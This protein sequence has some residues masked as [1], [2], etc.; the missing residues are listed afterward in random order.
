MQ[1][2]TPTDVVEFIVW[3][4]ESR[5]ELKGVC[6]LASME[7]GKSKGIGDGGL[8]QER[9]EDGEDGGGEE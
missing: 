1:C 9:G 3:E 7:D 4:E 8:E 5:L 6:E 2:W